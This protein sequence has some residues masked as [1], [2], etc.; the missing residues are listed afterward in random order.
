MIKNILNLFKTD[1]NFY[2]VDATIA[3][4]SILVQKGNQMHVLQ[5][6]LILIY[7]FLFGII[8][9]FL[10]LYEQTFVLFIGIPASMLAYVF[11]AKGYT[12]LSKIWNLIQINIILILL[13]VYTTTTTG[14]LAFLFL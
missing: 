10:G 4:E 14:I 1:L 12:L 9:I 6:W 5:I 8:N 2:N 11:F 7:S 3:E 13:C